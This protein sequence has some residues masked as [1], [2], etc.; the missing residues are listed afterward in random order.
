MPGMFGG[1]NLDNNFSTHLI[2]YFDKLFGNCTYT[3][4]NIIMLGG[5]A[6]SPYK[7]LY[8]DNNYCIVVDGCRELYS[9]ISNLKSNKVQE[10]F[11][12]NKTK[13]E[14]HSACA[15]NIVIYDKLLNNAFIASEITG[16]FPL[17]YHKT[18]VGLVFSNLLKPL[19]NYLCTEVDYVGTIQFLTKTFFYGTYSL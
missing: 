8:E 5:H 14:L 4:N 7:P 10:L 19:S 15:G 17:Y 13:L 12:I 9:F 11:K 18:D 3:K 6:Y 2:N 1:F 16:S